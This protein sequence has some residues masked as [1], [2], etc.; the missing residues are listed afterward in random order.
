[1]AKQ[2]SMAKG[3]DQFIDLDWDPDME[4]IPRN[5]RYCAVACD[6]RDNGFRNPR[7]Y[8]SKKEGRWIVTAIKNDIH[9]RAYLPDELVKLIAKF[10]A[11]P[12]DEPRKLG[13]RP[14][15]WRVVVYRADPVWHKTEKE[16]QK[17]ARRYQDIKLGKINPSKNN[18]NAGLSTHGRFP[19]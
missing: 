9:H 4:A 12:G 8:E 11:K 16:K 19:L 10:D 3:A 17:D 7:V 15:R 2:Q 1:M 14:Q 18:G 13:G 5:N 6:M